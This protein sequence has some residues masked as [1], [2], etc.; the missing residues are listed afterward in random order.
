MKTLHLD[1]IY[2]IYYLIGGLFILSGFRLA[3]KRRIRHQAKL[4]AVE[5]ELRPIIRQ[6][7]NDP[8]GVVEGR[9][10]MP[11]PVANSLPTGKESRRIFVIFFFSAL[12]S[13][14]TTIIFILHL[15]LLAVYAS[16]ADSLSSPTSLP[17]PTS[18]TS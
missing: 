4:N 5:Q 2:W 15:L 8:R 11:N 12:I 1:L 18:N 14:I 7:A 9:I 6:L 17:L 3:K 13:I 10:R 16:Y